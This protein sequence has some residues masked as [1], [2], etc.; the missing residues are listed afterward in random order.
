MESIC[1]ELKKSTL[2]VKQLIDWDDNYKVEQLTLYLREMQSDLEAK[3]HQ[4]I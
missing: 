2:N 3:M 4:S 1:A